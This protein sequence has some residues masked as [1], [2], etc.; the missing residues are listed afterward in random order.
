[1]KLE[2]LKQ[3][4]HGVIL[5]DDGAYMSKEANAFA[6]HIKAYLTGVAY[7]NGFKLAKFDVGHY[8]VSGFFE[9]D[10]KYVYFSRDIERYNYP[11]DIQRDNNILIRTAESLTDYRGGSNNYTNFKS[12][13]NMAL[14]LLS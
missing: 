3:R 9:K 14:R 6:R 11:V 5:E 13:A 10:G 2:V 7:E 8:Y 1:M 12:I 4:Y